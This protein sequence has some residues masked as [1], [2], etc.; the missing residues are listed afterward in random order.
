MK[1]GDGTFRVS[2]FPNYPFVADEV[3]KVEFLSGGLTA[4]RRKILM[5]FKFDEKLLGPS[6]CEDDDFSY[7][8][9]RKYANVYTPHARVVHYMSPVARDKQYKIAKMTIQTRY[10]LFKKNL[11][12]TFK[13]K[14]GAYWAVIGMFLEEVVAMDIESLRGL[15]AGLVSIVFHFDEFGTPGVR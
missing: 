15:I 12:Q 4:W 3:K 13:Y 9:S 8:V 14:I 11:P 1:P 5:E 6:I 7:R 2:G 10:Y